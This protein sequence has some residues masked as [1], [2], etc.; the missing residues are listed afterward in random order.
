MIGL[1]I[2]ICA[3][4][5]IGAHLL[6]VTALAKLPE[7]A[8]VI[9]PTR[10]EVRVVVPPPPPPEPVKPPELPP[11]TPT[12]PKVVDR[13]VVRSTPKPLATPV[14]T[15]PPPIDPPATAST[16]TR[17][18]FGVT[19]ESTTPGGTGPVVAVGNTATPTPT[20]RA[21]TGGVAP[22]AA[23]AP[24]HEV[25]K[26]P[27]PRGR[28]V[29]TYTDEARKA[30]IEGVVVLDLIVDERG[31]TR[32]IVVVQQLSHGLTEAAIAA[33][34]SCTFTPGE[35]AGVA[36]PVRVRAFKI[37]FVLDQP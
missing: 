33:L 13:P 9:R 23:P 17:P 20:T 18:V 36:V 15:T 12:P 31:H 30:A 25:T 26:L 10:V 16:T 22:L 37:R 3:V 35:R 21:T 27:L 24:A 14:E 1:R 8:R 4:L 32:D 29:G 7:R 28:C 5:S 34:N 19:M 11:P 2:I 6:A